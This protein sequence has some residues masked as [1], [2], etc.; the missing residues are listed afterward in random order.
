MVTSPSKAADSAAEWSGASLALSIGPRASLTDLLAAVDSA[1]LTANATVQV[2]ALGGRSL[3]AHGIRKL[4]GRLHRRGYALVLNQ[5]DGGDDRFAG[6]DATDGLDAIWLRPKPHTLPGRVDSC[7]ASLDG[8]SERGVRAGLQLVA[9]DAERAAAHAWAATLAER[10]DLPVMIIADAFEEVGRTSDTGR[11]LMSAIGS[12][13]ASASGFPLCLVPDAAPGL[14]VHGVGADP[15]QRAAALRRVKP[16][17]CAG[18]ALHIHCGGVAAQSVHSHGDGSLRPSRE[19]FVVSERSLR[20]VPIGATADLGRAAE[21]ER[22]DVSPRYPDTS[23]VTLIVPGCDLNCVFCEGEPDGISLA[24]S[25]LAGVRASLIAAAGTCTGVFFTGGEPTQLPWL[26]DA[27]QGARDL[28]YDRIQ[29]QSHA[30]RAADADYAQALV[31]AGLTAIDIPLYGYDP[32]SHEAITATPGSFEATLKG[33]ETL[34]GLGVRSVI[35]V[36]LFRSNLP[37]VGEILTLIASLGPDAAYLQVTG[38]V[39]VPGTYEAVAPS[40]V[41]VAAGVAAALD[42]V[43]PEFPVRVA[44]V[45]PCLLPGHTDYASRGRS[46]PEPGAEPIVL[47]FSEWLSTF[48]AGATRAYG[49]ACSSCAL[50]PDCDGLSRESLQHFGDDFLVSQ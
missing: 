35:H 37:V 12:S 24:P 3:S 8:L 19:P 32:A 9:S 1:G 48:S 14:P 31:D 18:C 22:L 41:Q 10:P 39:G 21:T 2:I 49:R 26:F 4:A 5:Q 36:T 17:A 33:L 20:G 29:M 27:I 23:L 38:E 28:G 42:H 34:R 7:L 11:M 47:P 43:R 16:A 45:P 46:R 13:R 25:A 15:W 6:L 30:G 40:P 44:D 50:R